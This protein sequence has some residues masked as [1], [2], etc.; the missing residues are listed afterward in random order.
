MI[1][2]L[3]GHQFRL[4][5]FITIIVCY[6]CAC[7]RVFNQL[8]RGG[9]NASKSQK[10]ASKDKSSSCEQGVSKRRHWSELAKKIS[11]GLSQGD[12]PT[13]MGKCLF[14]H[15]LHSFFL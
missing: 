14:S 4:S 11:L 3:L 6:F 5:E 15:V 12:I 13:N 2:K 1:Y 7:S 10:G 9:T 8:Q